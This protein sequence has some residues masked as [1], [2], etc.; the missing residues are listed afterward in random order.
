MGSGPEPAAR[1]EQAGEEWGRYLVDRPEPF[2][3]LSA[4]EAVNRVVDLLDELG[5]EPEVESDGEHGE[6]AA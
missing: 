5:F 1:A 2:T 4:A 3:S 6:E